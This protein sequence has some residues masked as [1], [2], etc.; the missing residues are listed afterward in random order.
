MSF[1]G[2]LLQAA[3]RL[4]RYLWGG[5]PLSRWLGL[6]ILACAVASLIWQWPQFWLAALCTVVYLAYILF[7][8]WAGRLGY[9]HFETASRE[10]G[11]FQSTDDPSKLRIEEM[12]PIRASGLFSVE[13]QEQYFVDIEADFETVGSREHIVLG[14]IHPSRFLLLGRW[15]G[16]Q[17]GWWYVFFEPAMIRDICLGSLLFGAQPSLALRV[18][19]APDDDS[20]EEVYLASESNG[21]IY[22]IWDDLKQD[23]P[24]SVGAPT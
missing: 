1:R 5:W 8:A 13:G 12:V 7:L 6:L 24:A 20:L 9:V 3:Y 17:L 15:P 21:I 4:R 11:L 18:T 19:Y 22:K 14:R 10:E 23:A 2:S 16:E